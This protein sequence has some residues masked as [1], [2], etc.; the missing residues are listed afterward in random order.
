MLTEN[1]VVKKETN[2]RDIVK[3]IHAKTIQFVEGTENYYISAD[4]GSTETRTYHY[5]PTSGKGNIL[6]V[7]S[8]YGLLETSIEAIE[9]KSDTLYDNMEIELRDIS[10]VTKKEFVFD[11]LNLIK[12]GLIKD[13][14]V[15]VE[16]ATS[17]QG[18]ITQDA[19]F[20]NLITNIGLSQYVRAIKMG[21]TLR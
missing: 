14:N 1:K 11:K 6:A 13:V 10:D 20:I 21:S 4:C 15:P 17:N 3:E 9:S 2:P 16:K 8:A 19:T 5:S 18:K 7:D 12:G